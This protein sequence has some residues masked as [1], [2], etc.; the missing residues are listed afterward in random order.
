M[1]VGIFGKFEATL[2]SILVQPQQNW[3][4][5]VSLHIWG[6][7]VPIGVLPNIYLICCNDKFISQ[8]SIKRK[9]TLD[10]YLLIDTTNQSWVLTMRLPKS[11][12]P[13]LHMTNSS[14]RN[15]AGVKVQWWINQ[16]LALWTTDGLWQACH[17]QNGK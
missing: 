3:I 9:R 11:H 5:Q 1:P 4:I 13:L 12:F 7:K 8:N 16:C 10:L 2:C 14:P 15:Y 17:H 6:W